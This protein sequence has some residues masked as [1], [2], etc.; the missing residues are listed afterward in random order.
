MKYVL[1]KADQTAVEEIFSLYLKRIQWMN[2]KRNRSVEQQ[3][4]FLQKVSG[5]VSYEPS[6]VPFRREI[7]KAV[8]ALAVNDH[9][10]RVRLDCSIDNPFLNQ[11]YES[12]GYEMAGTCKDGGDEGNRRENIWHYYREK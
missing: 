9:K 8:E 12:M 1:K 11:Y 2:E 4:L 7:I 6:A 10:E 5:K 3:W